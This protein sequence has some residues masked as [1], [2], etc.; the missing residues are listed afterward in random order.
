M[1]RFGRPEE[2]GPYFGAIEFIENAPPLPERLRAVV[3]CA[4]AQA[5]VRTFERLYDLA[6]NEEEKETIKFVNELWA[7]WLKHSHAALAAI[8]DVESELMEEIGT[9]FKGV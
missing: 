5:R 2:E 3:Y 8:R 6:E 1:T 4:I 7:D 9:R